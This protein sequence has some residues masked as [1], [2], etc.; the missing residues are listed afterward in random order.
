MVMLTAWLLAG[1]PGLAGVWEPAG[2]N[3]LSNG[4][5]EQGTAGWF[6]AGDKT[7]V[8]GDAGVVLTG[9]RALAISATGRPGEIR[10]IAFAKV[11]PARKYR[12][13]F[14]AKTSGLGHDARLSK[15]FH[16]EMAAAVGLAAF[17]QNRWLQWCPRPEGI[18]LGGTSGW[19][20]YHF[21]V[22]RLPPQTKNVQLHL[23]L[24][25]GAKGRVWFD[26]VAL[27]ELDLR[28]PSLSLSTAVPANVF[29]AAQAAN[30]EARVRNDSRRRDLVLRWQIQRTPGRAASAGQRRLRLA[31]DEARTETISLGSGVGHYVVGAELVEEQPCD[32][33]RLEAAVLPEPAEHPCPSLGLWGGDAML[34]RKAGASWT[35]LIAYWR[36]L[37]PER[38]RWDWEP[39]E[40]SLKQAKSAGLKVV[41]C[42]AQTAPWA[43]SAPGGSAD[44]ASYPPKRWQDLA[45]LAE[46]VVRRCGQDVAAWEIWNEPVIPWG[47]KG[48]AEDIVT[49]H[50]TIRDAIRR[51]RPGAVILG[52]CICQGT[53]PLLK[54]PAFQAVVPLGIL[55][56]CDGLA[57]HPYRE[58]LGPEHTF[59]FEE[60]G[61]LRDFARQHGIEQGPWITEMGWSASEYPFWPK[62][63]VSELDQAAY[64]ARSAVAAVAQG[65]RLFN[66]HQLTEWDVPDPHEKHFG[67]LRAEMAGPKP[68]LVAYAIVARYL[69][70]ARFVRRLAQ[71]GP[72]CPADGVS[73]DPVWKGLRPDAIRSIDAY[74]FDRAGQPLLVAWSISGR[75]ETLDLPATRELQVR[76]ALGSAASLRPRD[77]HVSLRLSNLPVYITG[78][79]QESLLRPR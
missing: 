37:E 29:T 6:V 31:A 9:K 72:P 59:F 36:Y 38:G 65:V 56:Y 24:Q 30:V 78:L 63:T 22:L 62:R 50:R 18:A 42:F 23:I 19:Q 20:T 28:K 7:A 54:L 16:G 25:D 44:S 13:S 41:L 26:D 79:G 55:Q 76:D 34:A 33:D 73:R 27:A 58:P 64:L 17:D 43:S 52:P 57:I 71:W 8:A 48:S 10:V 75:E 21:D 4:G 70:D 60:L 51:H 67:I 14:A 12:V 47:W 5:F 1:A 35:R 66:W 45:E 68:A 15:A 32:D 74:W 49:L 2:P 11:D 53:F 40:D 69:A 39:L 61:Q 46:K 3:L 77:G